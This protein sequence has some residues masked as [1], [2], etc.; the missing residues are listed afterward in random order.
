[1]QNEQLLHLDSFDGECIMSGSSLS[2]KVL[3]AG[4]ELSLAANNELDCRSVDN[5]SS[6]YQ[7]TSQLHSPV[8][9]NCYT[10]LFVCFILL[11]SLTC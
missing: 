1:M 4:G 8:C 7:P 6:R 2:S 9:K 3:A 11:F 10:F 5:P